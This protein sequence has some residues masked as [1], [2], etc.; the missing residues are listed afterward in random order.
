MVKTLVLLVTAIA[1]LLP[2]YTFY[3]FLQSNIAR[4]CPSHRRGGLGAV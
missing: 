4:H 1:Y 3:C 2:L